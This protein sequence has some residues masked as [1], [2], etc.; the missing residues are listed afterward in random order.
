VFI[1]IANL[2]FI[3][4]NNNENNDIILF[5]KSKVDKMITDAPGDKACSTHVLGFNM[6]C[7]SSTEYIR[8]F[9]KAQIP[10][11]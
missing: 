5:Y 2:V 6:N 9:H 11:L 10:M 8:L 3:K 4:N 7:L 1:I